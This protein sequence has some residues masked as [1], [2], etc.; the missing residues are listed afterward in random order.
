M[1]RLFNISTVLN[2]VSVSFFSFLKHDVR[3]HL[4]FIEFVK[5]ELLFLS[6]KWSKR[7]RHIFEIIQSFAWFWPWDH[8]FSTSMMLVFFT[9]KLKPTFL[10]V[11]EKTTQKFSKR[12]Y[13]VLPN[14]LSVSVHYSFSVE[15]L[16][17]FNVGE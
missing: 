12:F 7:D 6:L 13:N 2:T 5:T 8:A 17:A 9:L 10:I 15:Y 3:A 16:N 1:K 11:T 4:N 14:L